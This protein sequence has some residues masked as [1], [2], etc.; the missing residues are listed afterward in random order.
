[1]IGVGAEFGRAFEIKEMIEKPAKGTAP[2]NLIISGRY[3][4]QPE[5]FDVLENIGKGAGGEIQITDGMIKLAVSQAFHGVRFDGQT[6]N[7][8]SKLGFLTANIAFTLGRPDLAAERRAAIRTLVARRDGLASSMGGNRH[9][10]LGRQRV[11]VGEY[12]NS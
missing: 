1:M 6:Y 8:G 4:L 3:I 7:C 5:I 12:V 11:G 9:V 2:S 10:D